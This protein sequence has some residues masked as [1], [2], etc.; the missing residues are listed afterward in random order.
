MYRVAQ[1]CFFDVSPADRGGNAFYFALLLHFCCTKSCIK[2]RLCH[3]FFRRILLELNHKAI[4]VK[5]MTL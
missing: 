4:H 3:L 2:P 5:G 1:A